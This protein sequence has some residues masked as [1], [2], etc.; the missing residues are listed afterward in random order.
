MVMTMLPSS[1]W[2]GSEPQEQTGTGSISGTIWLDENADGVYDSGEKPVADYEV[3]LY[4]S[5][6]TNETVAKVT[7]DGSGNYAFRDLESNDYVIGMPLSQNVNGTEY[8]VPMVGIS[9][10]NKFALDKT[11][12]NAYTNTISIESDSES[13]GYSGGVRLPAGI[14]SLSVG[15]QPGSS[16]SYVPNSTVIGFAGYEWW[17]IGNV[18][19][20]VTSPSG[21][22]ITLW[23]KNWNF[24]RSMFRDT[25]VINNNYNGSYL[26]AA[27]NALDTSLFTTTK[28]NTQEGNYVTVRGS[29]DLLYETGA[30]PI[31]L[32]QIKNSGLF[33]IRNGQ[34]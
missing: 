31:P 8:L 9:G 25:S 27:M 24:D 12:Y 11:T 26:Q 10:D 33:L 17:V 19:Y 18:S 20:G 1:L 13:K 34:L 30:Q 29:L 21:N 15:I 32:L 6:N 16:T 22:S 23:S 5:S 2:A 28:G 4:L 14:Q 7:T 3:S